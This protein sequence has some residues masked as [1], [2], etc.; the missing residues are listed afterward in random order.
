PDVVTSA[1]ASQLLSALQA[2]NI[3]LNITTTE[4]DSEVRGQLVPT[5]APGGLWLAL[6]GALA[7]GLARLGRGLAGVIHPRG[8]R[9]GRGTPALRAESKTRRCSRSATRVEETRA[10]RRADSDLPSTH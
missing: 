3:Y 4:F 1:T 8:S 2:G 7:L 6:R 10:G 5:P 9:G